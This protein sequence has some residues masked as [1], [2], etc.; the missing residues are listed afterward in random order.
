MISPL[1]YVKVVCARN[2][3]LKAVKN[4][5]RPVLLE[6]RR[7]FFDVMDRYDF[8]RCEGRPNDAARILEL[9]TKKSGATKADSARLRKIRRELLDM[10]CLAEKQISD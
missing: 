4:G 3:Y 9:A 5:K 2:A 7:H 10:P 6:K 8:Y 1:V